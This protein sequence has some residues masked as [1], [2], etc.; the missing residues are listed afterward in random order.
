MLSISNED[1]TNYSL[2]YNIF[3][4]KKFIICVQLSLLI[5]RNFHFPNILLYNFNFIVEQNY[6][7]VT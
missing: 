6:F 7:H 4:L 1:F 2:F 5:L 3:S